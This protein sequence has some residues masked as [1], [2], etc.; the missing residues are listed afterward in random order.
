M[1]FGQFGLETQE[2]TSKGIPSCH[3]F[4]TGA[5][6]PTLLFLGPYASIDIHYRGYGLIGRMGKPNCYVYRF[7]RY[8][9]YDVT[10]GTYYILQE[11]PAFWGS[12]DSLFSLIIF[13]YG[14]HV[15]ESLRSSSEIDELNDELTGTNNNVIEIVVQVSQIGVGVT[16]S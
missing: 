4:G 9:I 14:E 7:L 1:A 11:R 5:V 13:I 16:P 15:L 6:F 12:M 3:I 8:E 10:T 2:G